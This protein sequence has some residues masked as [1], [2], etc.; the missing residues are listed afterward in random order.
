M[1]FCSMS[2][3]TIQTLDPGFVYGTNA[4]ISFH[5]STMQVFNPSPCSLWLPFQKNFTC[6]LSKFF[7]PA[8]SER[9]WRRPLL[10]LSFYLAREASGEQALSLPLSITLNNC[11]VHSTLHPSRSPSAFLFSPPPLGP[12]WPRPPFARCHRF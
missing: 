7:S 8:P 5:P 2:K 4:A 1:Q 6:P 12:T 9:P 11:D 10:L 3:G